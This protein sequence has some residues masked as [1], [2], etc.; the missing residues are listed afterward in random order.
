MLRKEDEQAV[1]KRFLVQKQ[2]AFAEE[3]HSISDELKGMFSFA[4]AKLKAVDLWNCYDME[5]DFSEE[6]WAEVLK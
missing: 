6:E 4:A 5:A 1:V 2:E 3:K